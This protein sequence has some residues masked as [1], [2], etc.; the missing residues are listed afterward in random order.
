MTESPATVIAE[1]P[2]NRRER[3]R[4]SLELFNGTWIVSARKWFEADDSSIRPGRHGIAFATKHL[5]AFAEAVA[6]ILAEAQAR[7]LVVAADR[8]PLT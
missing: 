3:V 5:P 4:V 1:W 2:L 7:G 6:K 8:S